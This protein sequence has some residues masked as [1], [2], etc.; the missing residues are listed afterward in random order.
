MDRNVGNAMLVV[1][2]IMTF[3][4]W[5]SISSEV[6]TISSPAAT[7]FFFISWIWLGSFIFRNV[8]VGVMGG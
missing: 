7:Y 2:R 3:D 5:D 1:F 6:A 8:F 4:N